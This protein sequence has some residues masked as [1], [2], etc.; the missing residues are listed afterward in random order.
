MKEF[1]S[2]ALYDN[3][4]PGFVEEMYSALF[5]VDLLAQIQYFF[6]NE[7]VALRAHLESI[8]VMKD[9]LKNKDNAYLTRM[10][11]LAMKIAEYFN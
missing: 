9:E 2:R 4:L 6:A 8:L 11:S 5:R 1:Y 7:R 10:G 3:P